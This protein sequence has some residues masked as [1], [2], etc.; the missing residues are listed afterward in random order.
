MNQR[1]KVFKWKSRNN[2]TFDLERVSDGEA[3]FCAWGVD[4]Q[5]MENG[6]GNYSCAIIKRDDGKIENVPVEMIQFYEPI[7]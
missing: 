1:V 7:R 2:G 3:V 6:I 4:F 5:E